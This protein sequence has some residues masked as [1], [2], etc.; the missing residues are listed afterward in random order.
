MEFPWTAESAVAAY[1]DTLLSSPCTANNEELYRGSL[2]ETA[3]PVVPTKRKTI[4]HEGISRAKTLKTKMAASDVPKEALTSTA[5]P[6][7]GCRRTPVIIY[8]YPPKIIRASPSQF[9]SIVQSLTGSP[10]TRLQT[11]KCSQEG[12]S[13]PC[14]HPRSRHRTDVNYQCVQAAFPAFE[15]SGAIDRAFPSSGSSSNGNTCTNPFSATEI[16]AYQV[17]TDSPH[18]RRPNSAFRRNES[19]INHMDLAIDQKRH[20]FLN[21]STPSGIDAYKETRR[22]HSVIADFFEA[23]QIPYSDSSVHPAFIST[24]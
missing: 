7:Q 6:T 2:S 21:G 17:G 18:Y 15:P 1:N 20:S 13:H 4:R 8:S 23:L 19:D 14:S 24:D 9:M 5:P 22:T 11:Q 10:E 3:I 12:P 16:P